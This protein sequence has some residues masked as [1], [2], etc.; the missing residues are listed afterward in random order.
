MSSRFDRVV[1][2]NSL[3]TAGNRS[4]NIFMPSSVI[5]PFVATRL[6]I[7]SK[8]VPPGSKILVVPIIVCKISFSA[9]SREIF[10]F[11]TAVDAYSC[12]IAVKKAGAELVKSANNSKLGFVNF[13]RGADGHQ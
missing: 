8:F 7:S 10:P 3:K 11:N 1:S 12:M 4:L 9:N 5:P 6:I 2:N 13:H